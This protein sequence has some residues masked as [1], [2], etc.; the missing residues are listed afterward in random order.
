MGQDTSEIYG[1]SASM[2]NDALSTSS[3]ISVIT[4]VVFASVFNSITIDDIPTEL[5][6]VY[7]FIHSISLISCS[8]FVVI[9][10]SISSGEA[11]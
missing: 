8:I 6:E 1:S 4:S 9:K 3:L 10:S 11:H 7:L 2:G 5:V